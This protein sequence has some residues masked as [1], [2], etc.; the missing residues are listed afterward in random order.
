M[1][2]YFVEE[3][4]E[5]LEVDFV[6]RL[7]ARELDHRTQLLV[8]DTLAHDLKHLLQVRLTDEALPAEESANL[9]GYLLL[10]VEHREGQHEQVF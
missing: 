1:S 4:H 6:A 8:G 10:A 2:V 3:V 9:K 7:D 5:L